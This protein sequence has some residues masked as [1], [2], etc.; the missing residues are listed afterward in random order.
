MDYTQVTSSA[1]E[2]LGPIPRSNSTGQ[3]VPPKVAKVIAELGLRY[4]P[5][6][7]ADLEAH[8]AALALLTRD[9]AHIHPDLLERAGKQWVQQERFMPKASELI[10]I[11][12]KLSARPDAS[13]LDP[14]ECADWANARMK[15]EH[16]GHMRWE[17]VDGKLKLIRL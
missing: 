14:H 13:P 15:T 16:V 6:A 7:Q 12:Q 10:A 17:V 9:V 1:F 11:A 3:R 8:A 4:R 2:E 5:S